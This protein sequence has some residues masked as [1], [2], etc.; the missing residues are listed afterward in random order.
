MASAST[1]RPA[2]PWIWGRNVDLGV[3][4]A[5]TLLAL[6]L[7]LLG[8]R[9]PGRQAELSDGA[10]VLFVL[11]VDVAHVWAT[12]YRTYLDPDELRRRP[13]LYALVPLGCWLGG[14]LLH[15][16]SPQLFWRVLAY[17]AV[18]HFIRQQTGWAAIYRA[19]VGATR[20]VDRVVDDLTIYLATGVPLLLWHASLPRPFVWFLEGDFV[21]LPR[22]AVLAPAARA[23]LAASLLGFL[24]HHLARRL[25]GQPAP[26]G[27]IIVVL[28]TA[29][30]WYAGIALL[31]D[32]LSFTLL[33]VLPHGVPYVALLYFYA[34]ARARERPRAPG[35]R[36]VLLGV[37]VFFG[38]LLLF[39]FAEEALWDRLV[40]HDRGWLFGLVPEADLEG[41]AT[42]LV[43]LLAVPQATHYVLDAVLWRKKSGGEAQAEALGFRPRGASAGA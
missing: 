38:S 21:P 35:S 42:W 29:L 32:D 37:G 39:A 13:R 26:A 33:N 14:V 11:G 8:R 9:L 4:L 12:L 24:G 22:L 17:L 40:W 6:A 34:R 16:R 10:W 20:R 41:A 23:L 15:A 2:S 25:R 7:A 3:F 43:P 27:K 1:P 18:V 19:R 30:S 5:P 36:L 31:G 28:T